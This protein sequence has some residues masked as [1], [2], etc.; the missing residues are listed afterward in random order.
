MDPLTLSLPHKS[1]ASAVRCHTCLIGPPLGTADASAKN[2]TSCT[3]MLSVHL[4]MRHCS[5]AILLL[6]HVD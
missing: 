4:I 2:F 6:L 3:S 1:L 5:I